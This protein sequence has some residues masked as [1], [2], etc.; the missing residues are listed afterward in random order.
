MSVNSTEMSALSSVLAVL[1]FTSQLVYGSNYQTEEKANASQ[2]SELVSK[3]SSPSTHWEPEVYELA[4]SDLAINQVNPHCSGLW[5]IVEEHNGSTSC[6]CGSDLGGVLQCGRNSL[7]VKLLSCYCMSSYEKDPNV[8]VVGACLVNCKG[9]RGTYFNPVEKTDDGS[10]YKHH[11]TGQL[12]GGC[13]EGYSIS[14][15]SYNWYCVN[16]STHSDTTKHW[17]EYVTVAFLPLTVFFL[18]VTTLHIRVTSPALNAFVLCCQL[19]TSPAQLRKYIYGLYELPPSFLRW[20]IQFFASMYGIWNLDFFRLIYPSF[21]LYPGIS[22]L[23]VLAL[24]YAV[25]V[26]P[27]LL[28]VVTYILVELHDHN[29]T[30]LVWLWRPLRGCFIRFR[31][32][33]DIRTSLVDAFATFLLLAYVKFLSV[34][35]DLLIPVRLYNAHGKVVDTYLYFDA[36]IEYFSK[37]HS[38]LFILAL[39]IVFLFNILPLLLFCLY[40]CQCFQKLLTRSRLRCHILHTFMD[41]FQGCYKNRSDGN[42]D[43]RWFSA[44]YLVVRMVFLLVAMGIHC[45]VAYCLFIA[46]LMIITALLVGLIQPYKSTVFNTVDV[47]L[48]LAL[49]LGYLS[50]ALNMTAYSSYFIYIGLSGVLSVIWGSVPLVYFAI[51]VLYWLLVRKKFCPRFSNWL[52]LL[53]KFHSDNPDGEPWPERMTDPTECTALLQD[54]MAVDQPYVLNEPTTR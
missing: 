41:V 48:F 50:A 20:T 23:H 16:C 31:R 42:C 40:P 43:R 9:L 14:A 29:V 53:F 52:L 54:P 1:L 12:Y 49:A 10:T 39:V 15:Y 19:L 45:R 11:R 38:P 8:T 37:E 46:M 21:C 30:I 22:T 5:T 3:A 36:T 51:V 6:E 7:E 47:L 44:V 2:N 26:Y 33:L 32:N 13:E 24:D 4:E 28:I 25:A 17:V 18:V 34:S 35:M 27:L